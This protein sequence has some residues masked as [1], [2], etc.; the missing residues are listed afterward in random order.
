[1]EAILKEYINAVTSGNEKEA[2]R[3]GEELKKFETK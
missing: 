2:R 3:L 1:M